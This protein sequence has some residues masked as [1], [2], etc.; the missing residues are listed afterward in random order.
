[1]P[2]QRIA[3]NL[4]FINWTV[5]TG[6]A[7]GAFAAVVLGRLATTATRGYLAFTAA[8]AVGLGDVEVHSPDPGA[9]ISSS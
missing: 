8:C 5:L 4:A 2:A 9:G 1:M 3:E 7:V 6:L